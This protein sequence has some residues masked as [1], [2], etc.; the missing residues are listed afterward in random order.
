MVENISEAERAAARMKSYIGPFVLTIFLYTLF[1]IPGLIVN[2]MYWQ[3]AKRMS[4]IAG[5]KLPG[6]GALGALI[7]FQII[8]VLLGVGIVM[9]GG[10]VSAIVGS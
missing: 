5:R 7:W 3:D 2:L 8:L 6:T 10:V 1:Y 9:V 4:K